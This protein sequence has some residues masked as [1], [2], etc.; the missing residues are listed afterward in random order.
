MSKKQVFITGLG[1]ICGAGNSVPEI[2]TELYE[3][4]RKTEKVQCIS[5]DLD[6]S[7]P[8]FEIYHLPEDSYRKFGRTSVFAEIAASEAL[9][10][11]GI[12]PKKTE[13]LR[14]G[15]AM[16]TTVGCALT[17]E[18]F[19]RAQVSNKQ[20]LDN[21]SLARY[22]RANP[23]QHLASVFGLRGPVTTIA[24]ACS[25]GTD[26]IGIAKS[27]IENGY[28]DIVLAGGADELSRITYLGFQALLILSEEACK[29]FDRD[30]KGL[31]L[32]EGA[33]I[34]VLESGESVR[35]RGSPILARLAGY[36]SATD[37]FH[38][39][40]PHPEGLGL[41]SAFNQAFKDA[42]ISSDKIKFVNSHGTATPANDRTEG[43][44]LARLF[45]NKM[46]LTATKA[47]TGHT[48][49]AAGGIEA[50]ITVQNLLD[51][52]IPGTPGL[53][54]PDPECNTSCR[55]TEKISAEYAASDS[56]AFGGCNS[57][58]IFGG[59]LMALSILGLCPVSSCYGSGRRT[60]KIFR[61]LHRIRLIFQRIW[62]RS[63]IRE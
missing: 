30:R 45:G 56:L 6:K 37:A 20:E 26:A 35:H 39:T 52:K 50:V 1:C 46:K 43:P 3:N 38:L 14:I 57:V 51:Q 2:M 63:I 54:Y 21:E 23:S 49:G 8:V 32:G 29:P 40:A 7:Y 59:V 61:F 42:E 48:L 5:T 9:N 4:R 19:F 44:V 34:V 36:G 13:G 10:H 22:L 33:G 53:E 12:N 31:N 24:N 60:L 58:L 47:F 18:P 17:L 16:G 25:S 62:N 41:E 55:T 15:V 27:W 28:C 11:A